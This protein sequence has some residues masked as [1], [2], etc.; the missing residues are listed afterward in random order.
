M[1]KQITVLDRRSDGEYAPYNPD[2]ATSE[3][4]TKL[5][6][7][8]R[9]SKQ[10][11]QTTYS[12]LNNRTPE[13]YWRDSEQRWISF[14]PEQRQKAWQSRVVKPITRN[15]CIGVIASMMGQFIQ[16][17]ITAKRDGIISEEI[18]GAIK[19]LVE[20]SQNSDRYELKQLMTYIDAVSKG[21]SYIQEDYVVSERKI[22]EIKSWDPITGE[23]EYEEKT[24]LDFEGFTSTIISPFEIYLGNI[25]EP[26]LQ[27]QPWMFRRVVMPYATAQQRYKGYRDFDSVIPGQQDRSDESAEERV[28]FEA[29][30]QRDL[31][32]DEVEILTYQSRW[33]DQIAIV[34]NGVLLTDVVSP[35]PYTHKKYNLAKIIFEPLSNRFAYGKSL[36]DKIQG[37]QDVIDTLYRMIIDK[38]FLSIFPPLL[39]KGSELL[40]ADIIVPGKITPIDSE[41]DLMVPKGLGGGVGN[42]IGV[43]NLI[44]SSMNSSTLDPQLLGVP[45]GGER[46]ATQVLETKRG[47]Q[48]ILGLFGFMIAFGVQDWLDLRIQNILQFWAQAERSVLKDGERTTVRNVFQMKGKELKDGTIGLREI[49]FMQPNLMPT[50]ED[51]FKQKIKDRKKNKMVDRVLLNPDAIRHYDFFVDVKANPSDRVSPELRKALGLE[52]Y[53]RFIQ[54]DLVDK[55]KLTN[56]TIKLMDHDPADFAPDAKPPAPPAP[57]GEEGAGLPGTQNK[58]NITSQLAAAAQPKLQQLINS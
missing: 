12:L 30:Y 52:F 42:E 18:A 8:F 57:E 37:E 23:T 43:L 53:D 6:L 26:D 38:T 3:L 45:A 39:S 34:A 27:K 9:T 35:I 51:L 25:F 54:N 28:F 7:L 50:S 19:D 32:G 21:T 40:T 1:S 55:Q 22:K 44:E 13:E 20:E 17:D 31:E 33:D 47:A 58:G 41:G 48:T 36:P 24:I 46:S 56:Q 5:K 10:A 49:E 2:Q 11:R 29:F 15:K 14:V 16:P 4:L